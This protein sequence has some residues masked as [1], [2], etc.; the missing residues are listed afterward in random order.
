MNLFSK[1]VFSAQAVHLSAI[2]FFTEIV[3]SAFLLSFLPAF[4][5]SKA[6]VTIATVGIAI[7]IHYIADT[8]MKAAAGFLLDRFSPRSILQVAYGCGLV[9]LFAVYFIHEPWV[10]ISGAALLGAGAS[11]VWLICLSSVKEEKRGSQMGSIYTVWLA[12]LGLGPVAVN[13][14][15]DKG[16]GVS[17]CVLAVL[18][19]AGWVVSMKWNYALA[20]SFSSEPLKDQMSRLVKRMLQMKP[21]IPGMVLQTAAAGLLV[22]VLPSFAANHLNLNYSDYSFVLITG[23]VF[24]VL[25]LIPMGRLADKWGYKWFLFVGFGALSVF[26]YL[27]LFSHYFYST[28]LL[29]VLLG[30][31]YSA[32][33]PA[34][35]ALM[36]YFV[37]SDQK[38]MGWSVL[39]GVEGIG[40][41][42]GPIA[43]G[44]I[45]SRFNETVTVTV[46]AL[47]LFTISLFYLFYM[48]RKITAVP[49]KDSNQ[50]FT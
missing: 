38:T 19:C 3:R 50:K 26:L 46:S 47:L 45:A 44:W 40:I 1:K 12:S 29:A 10:L 24:T 21:L 35:N 5:V 49:F 39:S 14:A 32:V 16:F 36:S 11:P 42:I 6:G 31:S 4:A 9:G 28:L 23:G 25:F 2:L 17:F 7:S 8:A 30:V 48:E 20:P 13:F 18:W 22:P 41:M 37:P 33:L 15:L 43:G 34:W 27:L